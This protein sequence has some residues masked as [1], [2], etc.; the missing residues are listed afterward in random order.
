ADFSAQAVVNTILYKSFPNDPVVGEEDSKGLQGDGGKEM[1]DK[2]LSLVNSALDTPLNEKELLDAIDRGT[3]SGGP[4]GRMWT[5]DPIDG[6]NGFL[7]G[8]EGQYAVGVSLIIDGAVHLSVIG[9]P[10]YPVNFNN[11]KGERGCLFIA[12]KGQGAFQ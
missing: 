3:Y 11:P 6:T 12:V 10:N 4:T 5:L 1:R 8:E 9:S 7:R 2:V